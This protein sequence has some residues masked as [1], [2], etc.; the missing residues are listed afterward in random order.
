MSLQ[1][2]NKIFIYYIW[3]IIFMVL[4]DNLMKKLCNHFYKT[5]YIIDLPIIIGEVLETTYCM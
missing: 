4:V 1:L 5:Q 3:T 2:S